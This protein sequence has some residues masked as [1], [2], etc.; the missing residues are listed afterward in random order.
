MRKSLFAA[1]LALTMLVP[2]SAGAAPPETF[3]QEDFTWVHDFENNLLVFWNV[4][5]EAYCEALVNG[6][7]PQV[8]KPLPFRVVQ[9]D[10]GY[11]RVTYDSKSYIELWTLDG[12]P[13]EGC[14]PTA[15]TAPWAVGTARV[16]LSALIEVDVGDLLNKLT[17]QGTVTETGGSGE[18]Q[19][20]FT[21]LWFPDRGPE[22]RPVQEFNLRLTG[23]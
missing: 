14:E 22:A 8:V 20:S 7:Q 1:L 5:R 10:N 4:T 12:E 21:T 9:A 19:Y 6:T 15:E 23:S 11:L 3:E 17:G 13:G 16:S 2:L 18:W